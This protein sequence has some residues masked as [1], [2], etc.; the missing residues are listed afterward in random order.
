MDRQQ[1][2]IANYRRAIGLQPDYWEAHA[3]LGGHLGLEGNADESRKEFE[4][5]VHLKPDLP[6]GHLNLGILLLKQGRT[7]DARKQFEETLRLDDK[8]TQA[9]AYLEQLQQARTK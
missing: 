2:A 4:D 8:N 6:M 1:D 9:R 5:V 3:E 7:E